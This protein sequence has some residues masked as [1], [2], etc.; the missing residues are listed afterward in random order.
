MGVHVA[1][2]ISFFF[3]VPLKKKSFGLKVGLRGTPSIFFA[4]IAARYDTLM[5]SQFTEHPTP[6]ST[7][8]LELLIRRFSDAVYDISGTCLSL[9][10]E[11]ILQSARTTMFQ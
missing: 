4:V 5:L 11:S 7:C 3:N 9:A 8:A 1:D 6:N 2:F 10:E